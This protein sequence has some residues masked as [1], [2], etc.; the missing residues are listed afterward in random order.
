MRRVKRSMLKPTE[1]G[2][3]CCFPALYKR[4]THITAT[5]TYIEGERDDDHNDKSMSMI[6]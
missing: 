3:K 5:A 2:S 1:S 6:N 4:I